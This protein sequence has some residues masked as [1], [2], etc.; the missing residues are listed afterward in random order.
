MFTSLRLG[1]RLA[2]AFGI[3]IALMG[4]TLAFTL[5]ETFR[6]QARIDEMV[7]VQAERLALAREWKENIAVNSQRA[8][9]M[10]LSSD[11]ALGGHFAEKIKAVSERTTVIQKRY[12]EI[13]TTP[14]GRAG[15]D[16]MADVRKRYLAQRETLFKAR[17]DAARMASEGDVFKRITDEYNAAADAVVAYQ[18]KR[19]AQTAE[20]VV[21]SMAQLRWMA[22]GATLAS[23]VLAAVLGWRV[24]HS[25]TRPLQALR[26]TAQRVASGDLTEDLRTEAGRAET[27]LLAN[28]I[29]AMQA[30]LRSLVAQVRDSTDSIETASREVA[31][32]NADLSAR[33]ELTASSLQETASSMHQLTGTVRQSAEAARTANTLAQAAGDVARR[34]GGVVQEVVRT[35]D[36]INASSRK[37]SDIIGVID[38]IAFQTNILALN[39]AID[40]ARAGDEGRGFAVVA[41]EVRGLAQR[42]AEAAQQ[43][44]RLITASVEQVSQGR[45]LVDRAGATMH[46]VVAT[47]DRVSTIMA[48]INA[49]SREQSTSVAQVGE[50]VTQMDQATQQNAALVEQSAAAAE[51]L[52]QQA[53]QLVQ[54]VAVFKLAHAE[55]QA[56]AAVPRAAPAAD[57][58]GN[59]PAVER[60]GPNRSRNITRLSSKARAAAAAPASAATPA[61]AK[62]GTD[63]EWT[64]F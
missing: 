38:G 33:T 28:D 39:A 35:M 2:L 36:E 7:L 20:A 45:T 3:V 21:G 8:I 61:T 57:T 43:I 63:D 44:K 40:A 23:I 58:A 10:G 4:V 41:G 52:K 53:Q 48:G 30:A 12:A 46:E 37:I 60:R 15:Q 49:A 17:G 29:A 6:A 11:A 13:E 54:T 64:S 59:W 19:Q 22:A 42:S 55:A 27:A 1:E 14:E 25:V 56:A 34:G 16:R 62:T 24:A 31:A 9:A 51:S 47:I 26:R 18:V 50:A 5:T 32:G